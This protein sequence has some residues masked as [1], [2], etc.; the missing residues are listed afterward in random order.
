MTVRDE[1]AKQIARLRDD[2][3]AL[4]GETHPGLDLAGIRVDLNQAANELEDLAE[5]VDLLVFS[6]SGTRTDD[7]GCAH[8]SM[9][10]KSY[11]TLKVKLRAWRGE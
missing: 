6:G 2:A 5:I 4:A 10:E 8:V 3:N 9:S 11:E 1:V 7:P